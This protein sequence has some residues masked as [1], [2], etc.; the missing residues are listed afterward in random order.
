MV[1]VDELL[2]AVLVAG[3]RAGALGEIQS[4]DSG[5]FDVRYPSSELA[6]VAYDDLQAIRERLSVA[7]A[8][9]AFRAAD[10]TEEPDPG[11]DRYEPVDRRVERY[12]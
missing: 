10:A 8:D 3:Y 4:P 5:T 11:A 6:E 9:L 12:R 1:L 2:M 7:R